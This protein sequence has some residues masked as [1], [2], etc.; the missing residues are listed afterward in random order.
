[1]TDESYDVVVAGAGPAGLTFASAVA[2]SH[3]TLVLEDNFEIGKPVQCSGLVSPRVMEMSGLGEWHNV[4]KSVDF[5]SPS[6]SSFSLRG[7]DPKGYVI[8]R[9]RLDVHLAERAAREGAGMLL[10]AT[11][12]GAIRK[13]G[14]IRVSYRYRGESRSLTTR[15]LIGA[16]GISSAVGR[17]FGLTSFREIISCVQTDAV[18]E[19][20]N[21]GDAVGLYFGSG[22]APGFFAWTIPAGGFARIGLGTSGGGYPASEYFGRFLERLGVRKP[23]NL[24]GG[25]IP[26]GNRGRIVADGVMLIGDAAGQTKPISGGGIF[27]GMAA[28]GVASEVAGEALDSGDLSGRNLSRYEGR[29]RKGVGKEL[30]RATLVRKIFLQM[31]DAKLDKLFSVLDNS[32][33][34]DVMASGDIDFPTEL[35]PLMLSREPALWRFS[36]QLIRALI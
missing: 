26:V 28:A 20:I 27:T 11:Y 32:S 2:G 34:K 23:L 30:D 18:A 9:S 21:G 15:M 10:G 13:E 6:G 5:H 14:R 3:S 31:N 33:I 16:D 22:I 19:D 24:T 4:I 8:D 35:S 1:M 7:D 36:P 12:T 25:P 17:S 29:W